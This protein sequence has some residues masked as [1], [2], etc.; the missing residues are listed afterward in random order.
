MWTGQQ[1]S[2]L[3]PPTRLTRVGQMGSRLFS[4]PPRPLGP[5]L[6]GCCRAVWEELGGARTNKE[7]GFPGKLGLNSASTP[8]LLPLCLEGELGGELVC[9]LL[10][11]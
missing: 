4:G 7:R 8:F 10:P 1:A 2:T 6:G 9:P 5:E 11:A 3:S